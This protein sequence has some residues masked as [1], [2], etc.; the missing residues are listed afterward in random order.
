[1]F[2][3]VL[4]GRKIQNLMRASGKK[5]LRKTNLGY[6][7]GKT[8]EG[9]YEIYMSSSEIGKYRMR[10]LGRKNMFFGNDRP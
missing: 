6:I 5:H 10:M 8:I 4:D 1:M 9:D 7:S 2:F 3:S